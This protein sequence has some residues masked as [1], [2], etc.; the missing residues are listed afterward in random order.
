MKH[1]YLATVKPSQQ[2]RAVENLQNQAFAVFNPM[3]SEAEP[4]FPGYVFVHFDINVQSS[5]KINNTW[6]VG[7]LVTFGDVLVP[8]PDAAITVLQRVPAPVDEPER[9]LN[10]GQNVEVLTGPFSGITAVFDETN[11]QRRS[12]LMIEILGQQQRIEF[13]NSQF[14]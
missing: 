9:N 8:V 14:V 1:W 6:G 7:K 3:L 11:G 12:F 2:K 13:K 5:S 10:K 4:L